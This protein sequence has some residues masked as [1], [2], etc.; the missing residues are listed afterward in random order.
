MRISSPLSTPYSAASSGLISAKVSGQRFSI[1]GL[2]MSSNADCQ[3]SLMRPLVIQNSPAS[4]LGVI[5]TKKS[6]NNSQGDLYEKCLARVT[7][8]VGKPFGMNSRSFGWTQL[9][10]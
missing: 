7:I 4:R 2:R 10:S 3:I 5:R 1:Y 6:S 9:Q 8:E